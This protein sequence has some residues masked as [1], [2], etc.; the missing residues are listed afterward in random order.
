LQYGSPQRSDAWRLP[1]S[2]RRAAVHTGGAFGQSSFIDASRHILS[3]FKRILV[4]FVEILRHTPLWVWGLLGA[5]VVLGLAQAR[6]REVSLT[7]VTVLPLVLAALSLSGVLSAFG[8]LPIALLGWTA[9]I[10]AALTTGRNIIP[11]RGASWSASTSTLNLPGS[12]LPLALILGLF[13]IKYFAGVTLVMHPQLASDPV[14][15]GLCSLGYGVFSGLF[16]GRALSLRRLAQ[17]NSAARDGLCA[18]GSK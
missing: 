18:I 14:F 8:H 13:A 1:A 10:A 3:H 15:A 4:M 7:R 5:L 2:F 6:A 17:A 16:L 9:G 12:W 11:V